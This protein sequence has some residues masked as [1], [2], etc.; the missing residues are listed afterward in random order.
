MKKLALLL[1]VMLL[2]GALCF[3]TYAADGYELL[4]NGDFE[5]KNY[6]SW[7]PYYLCSLDY[8]SDAHTGSTAL[9][10][11]N[12]QH[13]TDITG[14]YITKQ[15]NYYGPGTY[16]VSAYVRLADQDAQPVNLQIA[17]G[18]HT[19]DKQA[20]ATSNFAQI[21][22]DKWTLITA[23]VN[24]QWMGE[25][26]KAEFYIISDQNQ[27]GTNYRNLL[28]DDCSMKTVSYV[29]E[30]YEPDTTEA[31]TNPPT[32]TEA[33]TKTEAPTTQA[34]A[35]EQTTTEEFI[36]EQLT[37]DMPT[38]SEQPE[39]ETESTDIEQGSHPPE[40]LASILLA[41]GAVLLIVGIVL[42]VFAV[43][44]KSTGNLIVSIICLVLALALLSGGTVPLVL[45][46]QNPAQPQEQGT[47]ETETTPK[48]DSETESLPKSDSETEQ[49]LPNPAVQNQSLISENDFADPALQYRA[50]KIE[51]NFISLPGSTAAEMAA[52]LVEYGF[53]GAATNMKWDNN[54]LQQGYTLEQF[55]QFV[56]AAHSQGVRIWLY[57]E[58]GY[59]S[60]AAGNLTV[61]DH[62]EYEAVRLSQ[63]TIKGN[64]PRTQQH[65]VPTDFVKVEYA[66]IQT[67][68]SVVPLNVSVSDG[69]LIFDGRSGDWTAYVYCVTKYNHGFE[70]NDS[71]PNILNRDAVARFI[72]V[73]FDTYEGAIENFGD[74]VEAI[75]DDEAQLL[76]GHH[77]VPD[78]LNVPVIPYDYNIFDTFQAKYG[79][80]AR[81]LLPL[82]YSG[83]SALAMRVR[84]HF[85]AHVGDLVSENFFGQIQEWSLA[86]GTQLSGHLLLEEQMQY[87][88]PVY[89]DYIRCSQQ[90]GYSGFDVLNV[91]PDPYLNE[92]STGG[93]YAS[94]PA[95]LMGKEKVMIE[96]CPAADPDEFAT[97]HLDYALGAM[98]FAY[99][100]GGNQVTSYYSQ[101]NGDKET[102]K[103]FNEYVGR[104][105]SMT[106]GAQNLSQVA[107]YYSIDA[108]A[109]AYEAPA[110]QNLYHACAQAKEN[111][112]LVDRLAT[113]LRKI[114]LDYVFLDDTSMQGGTVTD[115]GLQV[116]NFTFTTI[117]VPNATIMDIES[118]RVLDAL[119][120]KGVNVIFVQSMPALAFMEADQAEMEALSAKH[121]S[122][123][124]DKFS[125]AISAIT[126][127]PA[128]SVQSKM[129]YVYVSPYEKDGVKFFFL[130]NASKRDTEI[131]LSFEGA[132]GYRIYD[133]VS[134]EIFEVE[135]TTTIQ[136]Y[137]A[138]FVQPL[139]P[140]E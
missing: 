20:W 22:A 37:E 87:H 31:P 71:Y 129:K 43:T 115:S 30:P 41:S 138:L 107:I 106:V 56:E 113:G 55:A 86:H 14:Q 17:I 78:N 73:T 60:G 65:A 91:R 108:T 13:Y 116:G 111:D 52:S 48:T 58:Y 137:R 118:M 72:E 131:T 95:W 82:I 88:V 79:Y 93:K 2:L 63:I 100:D 119:I 125:D 69:Q 49:E 29:G 67:G 84:A 123:L 117:L 32:E 1:C 35:T 19:A 21:T 8:V 139:F 101:A 47:S 33:P 36:T 26:E 77:L 102:G 23:Q 5:A 59:P 50:L 27:E 7:F 132:V 136:S 18:Y 98:T 15:L 75:F 62:P 90:M 25:L 9:K 114:G 61:K 105:G 133:P 12:R 39:S 85:Y 16:Q 97:N 121:A 53:G 80:D 11:S 70:W 126:T 120:E 28:I 68:N 128:L 127:K 54:Y 38:Q 103:A 6:F 89:G 92:T 140:E 81:P 34:P 40:T 4:E 83:D 135:D 130:A 112:K 3:P 24:L 122:L 110:T 44:T 10:V 134:G 94:S 74:V 42:I 99:F 45:G 96:I 46:S 64:G 76:A 124:C 57:D 104:L 109:A 51:H 66:C